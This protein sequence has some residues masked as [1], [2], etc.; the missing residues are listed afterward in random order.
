MFLPSKCTS[1]RNRPQRY[2]KNL[3]CARKRRKKVER[4]NYDVVESELDYN[5]YNLLI[6]Y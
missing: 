6:T 5:I 3:E 2:Y 4:E 1:D